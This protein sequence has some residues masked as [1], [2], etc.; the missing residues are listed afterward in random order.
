VFGTIPA[1]LFRHSEFTTNS[2]PPALVP[3]YPIALFSASTS[4]TTAWQ[5]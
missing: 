2:D 5:G 3:L 4:V 1:R